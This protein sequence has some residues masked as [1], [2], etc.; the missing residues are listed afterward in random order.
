MYCRNVYLRTGLTMPT[1]GWVVDLGANRGLFSIWAAVSGAQAVA[2]EAQQGFAPLIRE[3]AR[4]NGV[5]ERV[6]VEVALA[7]GAS[8]S[9]ATVGVIADDQRWSSASHGAP[10]RPMDVSMPQLMSKYRIDRIGLLKIDIEGGEF[11]VLGAEEDLRWLEQVDQVAL[12][13]HHDF[14]EAPSLIDRLRSHGFAIDLCDNDGD[15][16]TPAS[17]QLNYVYCERPSRR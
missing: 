1:R 12:E 11:A 4:H 2:V 14:G 5:A 17:N 10:T 8:L 7:S 6:H 15:Y 16:V 13:I 3:L 9:G